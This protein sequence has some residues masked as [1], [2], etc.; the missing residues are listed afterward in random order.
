MHRIA[1]MRAYFAVVGLGIVLS[2]L[3]RQVVFVYADGSAQVRCCNM[4]CCRGAR[5]KC[6]ANAA[7]ARMT[8]RQSAVPEGHCSMSGPCGQISQSWVLPNLPGTTVESAPVIPV[9]AMRSEYFFQRTG[10]ELAGYPPVPAHPPE[11]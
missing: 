3:S 6:T 2:V 7:G 10:V 9:P 4:S 1:V 8:A 5:G 11:L